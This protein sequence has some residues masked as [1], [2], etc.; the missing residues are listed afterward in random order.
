MRRKKTSPV[1]PTD[2]PTYNAQVKGNKSYRSELEMLEK[3]EINEVLGCNIKFSRAF[4]PNRKSTK[5]SETSSFPLK[6]SV[7]SMF[8]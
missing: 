7:A 3:S 6:F 8:A 1:H 4:G 5:K 2:H